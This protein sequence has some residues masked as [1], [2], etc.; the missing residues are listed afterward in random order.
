MP[1]MAGEGIV[2]AVDAICVNTASACCN[3]GLDPLMNRIEKSFPIVGT[4]LEYDSYLI[5]ENN[6]EVKR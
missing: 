6:E 1:H 2:T 3:E 5:H 4:A